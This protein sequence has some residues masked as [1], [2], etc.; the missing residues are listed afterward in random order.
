M[1]KSED[2]IPWFG[3][4]KEK[5]I[6][7]PN[8]NSHNKCKKNKEKIKERKEKEANSLLESLCIQMEKTKQVWAFWD[9]QKD[10]IGAAWMEVHERIKSASQNSWKE[11][12]AN[13]LWSFRVDR[14]ATEWKEMQEK[15]Q[16]QVR[17][18]NWSGKK[19]GN[20]DF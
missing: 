17:Q 14:I 16:E 12:K 3:S 18:L 19:Q 8:T 13:S 6:L 11:I 7:N 10:M 15:C 1:D 9:K 2:M 20:A 5:W 4:F